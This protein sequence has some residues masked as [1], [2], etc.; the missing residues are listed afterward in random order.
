M[1]HSPVLLVCSVSLIY[2]FGNATTKYGQPIYI[3]TSRS[4]RLVQII[5]IPQEFYLPGGG[6]FAMEFVSLGMF[7]IGKVFAI[8]L[9]IKIVYVC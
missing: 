8:I 2:P 1:I 4:P 9:R 7:I 5:H 6:L 3:D